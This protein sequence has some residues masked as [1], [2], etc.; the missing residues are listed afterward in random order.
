MRSLRSLLGEPSDRTNGLPVDAVVVVRV[1]EAR[2]ETEV[3]REVAVAR[4]RNG[5]PVVAERTG[6]EERSPK[7]VAGARE[8]DAD[9][10]VNTLATHFMPI[11]TIL[12]RPRPVA[13]AIK[14]IQFLFRRHAPRRAK[15]RRR[16]VMRRHEITGGIN[17]ACRQKR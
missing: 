4:V 11:D 6:I 16:R 15:V 10:S 8:E 9:G 13:L 3:P 7:A 14:I 2:K 1:A 12:C 17:I 5:R